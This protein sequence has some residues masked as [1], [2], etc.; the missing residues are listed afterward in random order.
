[1]N[2]DH[3]DLEK[4][5]E[6]LWLFS[7]FFNEPSLQNI[8]NGVNANKNV[9]VHNLFTIGK[10]TVRKMEGQ[11]LFSFS[12]KRNMKV[13]TMASVW[14]IEVTKD[15]TT[16]LSLLLQR[17]VLVSQSG[18]LSLAEVMAHELSPYP[19]LLFEAKNKL[20]QSDKAQLCDALKEHLTT[21]WDGAGLLKSVSGVEHYVLDGDSLLH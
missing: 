9:T 4:M 5:R 3:V 13:E 8:S 10:Y 20:L 2:K 6:K 17:F 1:M 12:Y 11:Q 15:K 14:A 21:Q 19:P 7:P 16:D 18:G